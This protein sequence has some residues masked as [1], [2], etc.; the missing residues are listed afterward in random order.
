MNSS[1]VGAIAGFIAPVVA[2]ACILLAIATHPQFSWT[3]HALSDL[4]VVPGATQ[5]LFNG[6]LCIAGGLILIFVT[7]GLHRYVDKNRAGRTGTYIFALSA[8]ALVLIGIFN[9]S[10]VPAH[11]M[12]SVAFFIL[13]PTALFILSYNFYQTHKYAV[14]V[15]TATTANIATLPWILQLI[16]PYAPNVAIPEIVSALSISVWTIGLSTKILKTP[17]TG[18]HT[19]DQAISGV[20]QARQSY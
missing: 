4:G 18:N 6:G 11:Y 19:I 15:F 16:L 7:F 14:S 10:F 13:A 20:K 1:N 2:V 3:N 5:W 9:E 8:I 17:I 12:V